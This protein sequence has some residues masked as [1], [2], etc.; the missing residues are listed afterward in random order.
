MRVVLKIGG[1]LIKEAPCLVKRLAKEF[2][3]EIPETSG[4]EYAA[5]RLPFSILIVPGGGIFADVVRETDEKFSLGSDA[6]HWMA[7]LGMEQYA[8]YLRD[9][10][11]AIV[12]ETIA[13][14]PQG[15]SILLP[16]R[17]LRKEDPLPHTWDVTSD[18][19]AAWVAKQAGAALIK[20]TDVDGIFRD[21]KLVREI[22]AACC[23]GDR[24]SCIDPALPEFLRENRMDCLIV[25]GKCPDRVIRAVY[26]K[27]VHGTMVKGNI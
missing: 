7:I 2:G 9:K 1:S 3:S 14:L 22:S 12:I 6:A 15:V 27:P 17:F 19:I 23:T 8:C 10:T 24:A 25:N 4:G 26:G 18:T 21:G 16:Y 20:A 11:G 5:E 13:E